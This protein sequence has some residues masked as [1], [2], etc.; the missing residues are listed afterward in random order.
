MRNFLPAALLAFLL[1]PMA[2]A[3]MQETVNVHVVEVPV[4]VVS[5]DGNPIRGLTAKNFELY[6]GKEKRA[7]SG[8]DTIDFASK[9]SMT[10]ISP[11]NPVARRNF[12]ILFD[13]TFSSPKGL[14]RAQE[15]ARDFLAKELQPRD[16][17]A[18]ATIDAE[19]G[20]NLATAFTT[21]RALLQAAIASPN[22]LGGSDPL[23]LA[24]VTMSDEDVKAATPSGRQESPVGEIAAG[25]RRL[26]DQYQRGRIERQMSVLGTLAE[27]L[28]AVKGRKQIVLLSEGF[29]PRL[30]I[31]RDAQDTNAAA[32]ENVAIS[33][34]NIAAVDLES[35][36]GSH[37]SLDLLARMA[38]LFR[39]SDVVLHAVDIQ[40]VRVQNDVRTGAVINSSNS[41]D[42]LSS[43]TGGQVFKQSNSLSGDF[44]R[45]LHAQEVVYVLAFQAPSNGSGKFHDLK[46]KLVD[47]PGSARVFARAGYYDDGSRSAVERTLTNAEIVM[48]D[49]AQSDVPVSAWSAPFPTSTDFAQVPVIL[50]INGPGLLKGAKGNTAVVQVYVYAFDQEGLVRDRIY[51]KISLDLNK[52]GEKLKAGGMKYYGT[53]ALPP[54]T[55]AV[56]SLVRAGESD[57]RGFA[58][59][60]VVVPGGRQLAVAA[61]VFIQEG[62]PSWVMVKGTSH[63]KTNV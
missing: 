62:A 43:P 63:D 8:F 16:V 33:T 56:K 38:T 29:D 45:M 37:A 40:G 5:S 35:R 26:D 50:E 32:Q 49:I 9:N 19:K 48:N 36:Y 12:L 51:E 41:L 6:D 3:Q 15:A 1:C 52:V 24:G 14:L 53:L 11:I 10:A 2:F 28:R 4:T 61:P 57:V 47:V 21:D 44:E 25:S 42:L 23:R 46:V 27:T 55:Y 39:D 58:R 60:D 59:T 20:F 34:G 17:A 54:G 22:Q 30:V 13:L 31:G 7:I 18:V